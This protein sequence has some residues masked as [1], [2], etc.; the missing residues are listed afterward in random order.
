MLVFFLFVSSPW[1]ASSVSLEWSLQEKNFPLKSCT[2]MTA[3]MNCRRRVT[4]TMLPMVLTATMTHCTTCLRPL[5]RLM[6][7][8]GRSTL[9]TRRILTTLMAP[10]LEGEKRI[11]VGA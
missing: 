6:A 2:P 4:R 9:S 8:S 7:L 1:H 5:A 3:N 10:E 11:L